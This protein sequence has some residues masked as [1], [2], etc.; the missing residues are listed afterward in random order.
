[1]ERRRE[2]TGSRGYLSSS[3]GKIDETSVNDGTVNDKEGK[4]ANAETRILTVMMVVGE[5]RSG[6]DPHSHMICSRLATESKFSFYL[7]T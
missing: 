7:S 1:M 2:S 6:T 5:R 3:K 4:G